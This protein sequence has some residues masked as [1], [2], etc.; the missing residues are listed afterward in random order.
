M[1]DEL[2]S[3]AA[4]QAFLDRTPYSTEPTYRSPRS[5]LRDGRAH[6]FDGACF[7]AMALERIG[8]APR[9][10]DLRAHRDDDHVLAIYQVG[11]FFGALSKS[12]VVLL[13]FRE[14]VY[15][16][17]RE[18]V[19]SY[20]EFYYNLDGDKALRDYS[21]PIPMRRFERANWRTDDAAMDL[22]A[23]HMNLVRHHPI[24]TEP[25]LAGLTKVDARTY[26]AGLLGSDAAGLYKPEAVAAD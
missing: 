17:L 23:E 19:M 3:P 20:F 10:I 24:L 18:L 8:H 5:V 25:Q 6:C 1:L 26:E 2:C 21:S 15:R 13:R 22:I 7:A 9:I 4:I 14:P 12:N 16:S 11:R